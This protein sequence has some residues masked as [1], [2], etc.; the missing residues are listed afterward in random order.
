MSADTILLRPP[1]PEDADALAAAVA[2]S[3][4]EI[5]RWMDWARGDYGTEQAREW[6]AAT[7]GERARGSAF[8]F[9]FTDAAGELLGVC[10]INQ[11][12]AD[13]RFANLGYWIRTPATE[14][15]ATARAVREVAAW[16]FS[17]TA[18]V[19]LEMV[20]AVENTRSRRVAEKAGGA[21]EGVLRA[22]LRIGGAH[23][24]AAMY[25]LVKPDASRA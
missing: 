7:A 18:L 12:H 11:I 13:H 15:G 16:A 24:D 22:R 5:G 8:E 23:H 9:L 14:R 1:A 20:V 6:I 3:A 25:S 2:E 21:L 19:R 4:R 17:S 10:G